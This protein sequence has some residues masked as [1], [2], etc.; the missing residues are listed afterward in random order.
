MENNIPNN[1]PQH[2][3][4]IMDGNGRWARAR[5]MPR[6]EGHRQGAKALKRIVKASRELG[7][8]Y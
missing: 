8:R 1:I 6:V 2:V 4:I 3:V 7:I 5:L